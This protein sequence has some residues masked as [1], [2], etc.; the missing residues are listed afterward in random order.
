MGSESFSI[1][2][3]RIVK[4]APT[5][6]FGLN[7]TAKDPLCPESD[8]RIRDGHVDVPRGPG[9]GITIDEAARKKNTLLQERVG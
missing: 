9:L 7:A 4:I 2:E 6:L 1:S 3:T 5:P 8:F